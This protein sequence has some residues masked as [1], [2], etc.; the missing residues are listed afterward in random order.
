MILVTG[1]TGCIGSNITRALVAR[2]EEVAVL[3]P[4]NEDLGA[5]ADVAHDVEHRLGDVR[6]PDGV[7]R[8]MRGITQVYHL[9]G[10]TVPI[11]DL[12]PLM[13]EVNVCG[14]QNVMSSALKAGARVVHTSSV[15]AV[16]FPAA[17]IIADEGFAFNA[18]GHAY[19]V[20]KRLG[21]RVVVRYVLEGLD[22]VIVNPAASL[23]PGGDL[24]S[25]WASLITRLRSGQLPFFT[26]GGLSV[27]TGRD[28]V[29]AHLRAMERGRSGERYIL[30][31]AN[32]TYRELFSLAASVI[33]VPRPRWRAPDRAIRIASHLVAGGG[34]VISDPMRRPL[35]TPENA[36]LLIG[37]VYYD[38][39]K[40][41]RDLGTSATSLREAI[42]ELAAW[43]E[44]REKVL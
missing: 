32:V 9:A 38:A 14:T 34:R 27:I 43:C 7:E 23:A 2:G 40:A 21:E 44:Q 5:I 24:R 25:G 8:A 30:T 18:H 37:T 13:H 3:R 31:S 35:L 17:G 20:S 16:G 39:G 19:A 10:I 33:G 36:R 42:G 12:A 15:S 41:A 29:D 28:V 11:N 26:A 1:A 22:A 6:D 4:P